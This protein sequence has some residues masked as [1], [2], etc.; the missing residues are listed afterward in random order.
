MLPTRALVV[1]GP[2]SHH[3][4]ELLSSVTC[5]KRSAPL[6]AATLICGRWEL[7]GLEP[8]ACSLGR[9]SAS[10]LCL[11]GKRLL[12]HAQ[13]SEPA[14]LGWQACW[15]KTLRSWLIERDSDGEVDCGSML[16]ARPSLESDCGRRSRVGFGAASGHWK[17]VSRRCQRKAGAHAVTLVWAAPA[18]VRSQ[19]ASSWFPSLHREASSE[20]VS[21]GRQPCSCWVWKGVSNEQ[22]RPSG[23]LPSVAAMIPLRY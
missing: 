17:S 3:P 9:S 18:G 10:A 8:S 2:S 15:L 21:S 7:K 5:R 23:V 11:A 19:V 22:P 13:A 20:C 16:S 6:N 12:S 4:S 14:V 1:H